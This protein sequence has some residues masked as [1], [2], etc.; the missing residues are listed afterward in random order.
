MT[1]KHSMFQVNVR[2]DILLFVSI[3]ER[4]S[5]ACFVIHLEPAKYFNIIHLFTFNTFSGASPYTYI[6][7]EASSLKRGAL[8]SAWCA[9]VWKIMETERK[10]GY[11]ETWNYGVVPYQVNVR[12][13]ASF[14]LF[15]MSFGNFIPGDQREIFS[16]AEDPQARLKQSLTQVFCIWKS[17]TRHHS[18]L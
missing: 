18:T 13:K 10:A 5:S 1:L 11:S 17:S 4:E 12:K 15:Q 6:G 16:D 3:F 9:T 2:C 14:E 8:D 7:L